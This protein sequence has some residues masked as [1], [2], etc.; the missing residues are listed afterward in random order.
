[1]R[2]YANSRYANADQE[3]GER[4]QIRYLYLNSRLPFYKIAE[5]VGVTVHRVHT[6]CRDDME[7]L[8]TVA[9]REE[10][11]I[12]ESFLVKEELIAKLKKLHGSD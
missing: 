6:V 3:A 1:M 8:E 10:T 2:G 5:V 9:T 7:Y 12:H 4:V 11:I